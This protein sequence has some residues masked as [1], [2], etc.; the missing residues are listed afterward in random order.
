MKKILSVLLVL[1]MILSLAG[2]GAKPEAT[3]EAFC[4]ALQAS[5][6]QALKNLSS[7]D[8]GEEIAG[9]EDLSDTLGDTF[10]D[11]LKQLN[12]E[13][14]YSVGE[15]EKDGKTAKVTVHFEYKSCASVVAA[16]VKNMIAS[17]FSAAFGGAE[18]DADEMFKQALAD[19][20]GTEDTTSNT[21]DITLSLVK[22]GKEWK[23]DDVPDE[24]ADVMTAGLV[25]ALN[26]VTGIFG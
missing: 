17:A 20:I 11:F 13:M 4:K 25:S 8:S 16:A 9:F 19:A 6:V 10:T 23:I 18:L 3:A 14:K 24:I 2:C 1:C 7:E 5:D 12:S 26:A 15:V 22:V 21:A